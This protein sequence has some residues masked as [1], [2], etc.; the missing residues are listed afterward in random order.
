VVEDI[1]GRAAD[2]ELQYWTMAQE[3][4]AGAGDRLKRITS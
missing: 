1:A 3:A 2:L 4:L